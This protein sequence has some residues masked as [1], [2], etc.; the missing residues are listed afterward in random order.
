MLGVLV[1]F[2]AVALGGILGTLLR[3]GV[4]EKYRALIQQGLALCVLVIGISGAIETHSALLLIISIVIGCVIGALIGIQSGVEK[5]GAWAQGKFKKGGFA[6]GFVSATLLFSIGSMAVVGSLDAGF[7]DSS[8]LLAKSVIDGVSALIIASTFGIGAACAAVPMTVYQGA[9]A[10]MAVW[11]KPYMSDIM[12]NEMSAVGSV[13]I[14][15]L[16]FNMLGIV[17]IKVADMLPAML[18]PCAYYAIT[19]IFI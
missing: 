1:N 4:P 12:I 15:A 5:L 9:I 14:M 2:G 16:G 10:L 6:E 11:V 3:G 13:L 18:V 8:T 17:K 7:G 19:G